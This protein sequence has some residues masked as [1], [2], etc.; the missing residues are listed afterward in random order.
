MRTTGLAALIA[1]AAV[2]LGIA[3][4]AHAVTFAD[5]SATDSFSNIQW[6]QS[7]SATSGNL[8]TVGV[9]ESANVK[10]SFLTPSLLN[11]SNLPAKFTYSGAGPASDPASHLGG[12]L[13]QPNLNGSFSFTYTGT[14]DLTV[15]TQTFHTGANLLSGTFTNGFISG[16]SGS[17]VGAVNNAISAG[18]VLNFSSDFLTFA[19]T[20]DKG[21]AFSLTSIMGPLNA[22]P[23]NA[24]DSFAAVSTGSFQSDIGGGGGAGGVPEPATWALMIVG[25]GAVG[26]ALRRR[27]RQDALANR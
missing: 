2:G 26:A 3:A 5:Y 18:G 24:L 13:M 9:G 11:L 4:P 8:A 22:A 15:G 10:F 1:S 14:P 21:Y 17:G 27:V 23:G 20:G 25:F 16:A 6:T 7:V 19:T 12:L